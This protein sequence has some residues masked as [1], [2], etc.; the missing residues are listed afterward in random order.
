MAKPQAADGNQWWPTIKDW[1]GII[2]VLAALALLGWIFFQEAKPSWADA[3][4]S[5]DSCGGDR[6]VLLPINRRPN[7]GSSYD[8]A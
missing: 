5:S 6:A 3:T 1:L 7:R 4:A 8:E 2:I